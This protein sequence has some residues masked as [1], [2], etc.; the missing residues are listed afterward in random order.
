MKALN[1][2][3]VEVQYNWCGSANPSPSKFYSDQTSSIDWYNY[4]DYDPNQALRIAKGIIEGKEIDI[5]QRRNDNLTP[6]SPIFISAEFDSASRKWS[7]S[8]Y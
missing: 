7:N 6:L 2:S 4:L 1:N 8:K 5:D 3:V